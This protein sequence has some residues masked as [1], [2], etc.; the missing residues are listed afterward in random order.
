[1]V[2]NS[3]NYKVLIPVAGVSRHL[4]ELVEYTNHS[5]IRIGK[6][7]TLSYIIESYPESVPIIISLGHFGQ[8]IRDFVSLAY[9]ERPI[10][11]VEV[12]NYEGPGSSLGYSM[13]ATKQ[14]LQCP[15]IYHA[16]DTIVDD[17]IPSPTKN[18]IGAYQSQ[19]TTNYASLNVLG[20]KV[21]HIN[22]K[23]STN[24]GYIHNIHI[25]LVAIK[26]YA[27]FWDI[28]ENLYR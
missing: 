22:D 14:Y 6:K 16:A 21:I 20:D 4:G 13:L 23:D 10:E 8:Q 15:F 27:L 17:N 2:E 26:D 12:D 5:L 3:F 28:L 9:P 24:Y 19:D 18:W 11:F 25:G 7:P 1:M